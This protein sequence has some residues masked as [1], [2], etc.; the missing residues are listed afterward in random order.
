[1]NPLRSPLF[2]LLFFFLLACNT[3]ERVVRFSP[4]NTA[5]MLVST[6]DVANL[7]AQYGNVDGVYLSYNQTLEHNV[8]I[9]FTS[10]IPH[11]KFY[12]IVDRSHVIFNP[13]AP[14]LNAFR[15]EVPRQSKLRTIADFG[16]S[17]G[18]LQ[19]GL[20]TIRS[21]RG[22]RMQKGNKTYTLSYSGFSPGL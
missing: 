21:H 17:A 2:L 4:D 3:T 16:S 13:N 12:E 5:S 7:Q 14:E 1:M 15:L 10:T 19:Y 9:A 6:N 8:S 20:S 11:W 22:T 18:C